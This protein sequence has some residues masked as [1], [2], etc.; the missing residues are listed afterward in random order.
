MLKKRLIAVIGAVTAGLITASTAGAADMWQE[1]TIDDSYKDWTITFS[2]DVS[3]DALTETPI[4]VATEDGE[5]LYVEALLDASNEVTV[6]PPADGYDPGASYELVV[7]QELHSEQGTALKEK[8]VLPFTM[9]EDEEAESLEA[10]ELG[11]EQKEVE[12]FLGA[13][14]ASGVESIYDYQWDIYHEDYAAYTQVGYND[15]REAVGFLTFSPDSPEISEVNVGDD[16]VDARDALGEPLEHIHR[17]GTNYVV[18]DDTNDIFHH[19]G[20]YHWVFYDLAQEAEVMA[21]AVIDEAAEE[22]LGGFYGEPSD[23]LRAG[24]EEQSV[25]QLGAI[26]VQHDLAPLGWHEASTATSRAHSKDMA[27]GS[28]L[29]HAGSDGRG[30]FERLSDDGFAFGAAAENVAYGTAAAV[31]TNVGLMNSPGHRAN[32]L[33]GDLEQVSVGFAF[34]AENRPFITQKFLTPR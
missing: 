3:T 14:E 18:E 2:S 7:P 8:A 34:D 9:E 20:A 25:A 11:A 12:T 22:A 15:D 6:L 21:V 1:R 10:L 16:Q 26:R 23:D 13:P 4:R 31:Y 24:L 28:F 33:N 17:E 19:D 27:D 29:G 32:I 30:P 5:T